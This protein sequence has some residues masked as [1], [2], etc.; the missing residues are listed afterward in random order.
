MQTWVVLAILSPAIF[1]AV[2]FADKYILERQVKDYRGYVMFSAIVGF[3]VGTGIWF[4]TGRPLLSFR[5]GLLVVLVGVVS[6]F[7]AALYFQLMAE[8]K[9]SK[10]I[11]ALQLIP[12]F[13]LVL[14]FLFLGERIAGRAL[15]GFFL[16]LSSVVVA[17]RAKGETAKFSFS[18]MLLLILGMDFLWA[19]G[20]VLF[21]FVSE[22]NN[23]VKTLS[24]ESWGWAVGGAILY[25][26]FPKVRSTFRATIS[27]LKPQ[28][29]TIIFANELIYTLGKLVSFWAISLGPVSLVSA[30]GGVQVFYGVFCG[31][32]L[33]LIVPKIFAEDI[34]RRAMLTKVALASVAAVGIFLV[35]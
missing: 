12:V 34:T 19:I 33:T 20:P 30:L 24:Y 6:I 22:S 21:K 31:W 15:L 32:I 4:L 5:D 11:F 10:L 17:S 8:E 2:N 1:T 3:I 28:A 23:F 18:K 26:F 9:V 35:S 25:L 7:A 13:V 29:F 14:S 27:S 16:I